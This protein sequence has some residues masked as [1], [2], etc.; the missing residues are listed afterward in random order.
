MPALST[1][2][3]FSAVAIQP[4][5]HYLF[6]F[7]LQAPEVWWLIVRFGLLFLKVHFEYLISVHLKLKSFKLAHGSS[8]HIQSYPLSSLLAPSPSSPGYLALL[9]DLLS[10]LQDS[11]S[12]YPAPDIS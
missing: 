7:W 6:N 8:S 12:T 10:S 4:I 2:L 9:L 5:D 3:H 1:F 11:V